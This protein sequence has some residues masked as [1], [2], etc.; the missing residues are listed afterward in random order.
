MWHTGKV[1]NLQA[2]KDAVRGSLHDGS[3]YKAFQTMLKM[4]GV[5][6]AVAEHVADWLPGSLFTSPLYC[7]T[8]GSDA[9]LLCKKRY[10]FL[11]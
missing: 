5:S 6:P 4:Q 2:G 8:T 3:A 11:T 10:S 7:P 1:D 9:R